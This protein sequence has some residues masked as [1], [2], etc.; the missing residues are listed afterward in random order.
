M[1][2]QSRGKCTH[3]AHPED[4]WVVLFVV[5][6]AMSTKLPVVVVGDDRCLDDFGHTS[7]LRTSGLRTSGFIVVVVD[8]AVCTGHHVKS[9]VD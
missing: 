6:V 7:G 2:C 9:C 8:T 4:G 3:V 1:P 5:V